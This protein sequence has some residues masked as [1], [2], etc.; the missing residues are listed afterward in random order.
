MSLESL[1]QSLIGVPAGIATD[2]DA[3]AVLAMVE[4]LIQTKA[5]LEET[6]AKLDALLDAVKEVIRFRGHSDPM[7]AATVASVEAR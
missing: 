2:L 1:K 4:E 6:K 7:L 3:P 5:E